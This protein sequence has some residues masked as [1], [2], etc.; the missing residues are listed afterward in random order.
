MSKKHFWRW[1]MISFVALFV[2]AGLQTIA[3]GDQVV[4]RLKRDITFL[5]SEKCEGRGPGTKGLE[6]AADY[7]ASEFKKAGLIPGG[8]KGSYFQSFSVRGRAEK[9]KG[10]FVKLHGPLGQTIE[11]QEGKDFEVLGLSGTGKVKNAPLVFVGFG[12]SAPKAKYDD[13]KDFD[14]AG[15]VAI[16]LRHTPRWSSK[17]APFDGRRKDSHAD[18]RRTQALALTKKAAAVLL[19][20]DLV[21]VPK[22]DKLRSFRS[23]AWSASKGNLPSF[24]V[25]RYVIDDV[26]RSALGMGLA[27]LERAINRDLKPRST[28]LDGWTASVGSTVRRDRIPVKN[29]VG[30]LEGSGPLAKETIVIGAHY[31]HLGYGGFGSR[32]RD[33]FKKQIHF[34]ADDNASGTT[35]LLEIARQLAEDPKREG[36]KLVFIAFTAE[37]M[38]LLGSKYYNDNPLFSLKDT[39][40]MINFDMVGRMKVDEKTK[41]G[42][43][44]IQ[45]VGTGKSFGK[46]ID[47]IGSDRLKIVKQ[48]GSNPGSDHF[49]FYQKKI[50]VLFFFSGLHKEYH[51][52]RDTAEKINVAGMAHITKYATK[53]ISTLAQ[54]KDRPEYV[55]VA[56]SSTRPRVSNIPKMGIIPDY[57]GEKTGLA[58]SGVAKNGPAEKAGMKG[59]DRIVEIAGR[60]VTDI[61]TYM[62][63]MSAQERGKP[64]EVGVIR[65]GK[66][67]KLKVVPR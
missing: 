3:T 19:V 15:K 50:P 12:I 26:T 67:I 13:Y 22:G 64:L 40:A 54:A 29:V 55:K 8:R 61:Q 1:P 32:A 58:I 57:A 25:R 7:I 46:V 56:N 37:E 36:R 44:V 33:P 9:G 47:K 42:S 2:A 10:N 20:N 31:D 49:P 65:G 38:G 21:E 34:G 24:H 51:T 30:V 53:V 45:G 23:L 4:D 14:V 18:L 41:R 17:E 5:A 39:A 35:A 63:V 62:V 66:K 52:P 11:L 59:G 6:L 60:K 28:T 16:V 48:K 27:D 43:V